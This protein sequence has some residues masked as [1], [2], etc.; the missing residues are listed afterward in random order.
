MNERG[1]ESS[2]VAT[3][4]RAEHNKFLFYLASL[5]C[6]TL[7]AEGS[8]LGQRRCET[9]IHKLTWNGARQMM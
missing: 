6:A 5:V 7:I 4:I 8:I 2:G 1:C 9:H 3:D